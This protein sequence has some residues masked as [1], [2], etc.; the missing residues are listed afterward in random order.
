[1]VGPLDAAAGERYPPTI[2]EPGSR[3]GRTKLRVTALPP[4]RSILYAVAFRFQRLNDCVRSDFRRDGPTRSSYAVR[5]QH[6]QH[7]FT[8][9]LRHRHINEMV[10][11]ALFVITRSTIRA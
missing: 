5:I 7:V 11:A 2:R 3:C 10:M 9:A 4:S 8:S 6:S 1:M